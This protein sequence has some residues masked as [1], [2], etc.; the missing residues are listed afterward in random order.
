MAVSPPRPK[1]PSLNALRAFEAAARL[2]SFSAAAEELS[3]TPGAVSQHI[4][5]LEDWTKVPLFFRDAQG[6]RLTP[7]GKTLLPDFVSAFDRLGAAVR[8]LQGLSPV[9]DIHIATMPSIA[10]LWLSPRLGIIRKH[11]PG[12]R[13]SVTA[14]ETPPNLEREL[15]D[16][17]LFVRKPRGGA[18]EIVLIEDLVTPVCAPSFLAELTGPEALDRVPLLFDDSWIEDW[19]DWFAASGVP[20]SGDPQGAHYSLYSLALEETIAGAGVL[21]GHLF[22]VESA[23]AAGRLCRPFAKTTPTGKA[24]VIETPPGK[25]APPEIDRIVALLR[26]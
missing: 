22:L 15:F 24:L 11:L 19:T 3:V 14:L 25:S 5:T 10:Q 13:L 18:N 12:I 2:G 8:A 20:F 21:M 7:S 6:V 23:L 4:K 1:S 9:T 26:S 16:L 17:S